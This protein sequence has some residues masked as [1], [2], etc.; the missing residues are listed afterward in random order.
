[1]KLQGKETIFTV[2]TPTNIAENV[3][4]VIIFTNILEHF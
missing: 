2:I 3:S 1:M 4:F